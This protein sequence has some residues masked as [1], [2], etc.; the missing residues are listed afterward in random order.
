[1]AVIIG[2]L[3]FGNLW[4]SHSEIFRLLVSHANRYPQM[5]IQDA[6]K[7][8][9]QGSMG[10][11]HLLDSFEEYEQDLLVE[12]D[13][14]A[15]DDSIPIWENIRP[16]GQIVRFYLAPYKARGGQVPQLLTLCFWSSTLFEGNVED[17]KISW[18][19]MIKIVRE[20]RWNKFS[21]DE[22]MEFDHWLKKYQ[23]PP[24]HHTEAYRKAY[25]PSYRLL[26]REFL[27]ILAPVNPNR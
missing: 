9:Y 4:R 19:T 18:E 25:H 2:D 24:V 10:S 14:L 20:K 26:Q 3:K 6:Y 5:G 17:L 21:I 1:M 11:E 12:W 8:L 15:E 7:L 23:F 22:I 13:R 27:N 16:D